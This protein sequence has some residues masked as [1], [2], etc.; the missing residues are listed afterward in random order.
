[1]MDK[2]TLISKQIGDKM[3][4]AAPRIFQPLNQ[5]KTTLIFRNYLKMSICSSKI[6][7]LLKLINLKQ[8]R[9]VLYNLNN[10]LPVLT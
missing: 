3:N 8:I 2:I 5:T 7:Q 1:M 6:M 10:K 4:S 9:V